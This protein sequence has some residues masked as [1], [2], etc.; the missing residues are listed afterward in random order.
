MV[1]RYRPDSDEQERSFEWSRLA[2]KMIPD[3]GGDYVAYEDYE[4]LEAENKRLGEALSEIATGNRTAHE[5]ML[6]ARQALRE[7]NDR[8]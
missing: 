8:P 2:D 3:E 4:E 5:A 7:R 6:W 1:Q